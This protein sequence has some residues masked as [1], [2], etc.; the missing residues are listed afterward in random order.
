[1]KKFIYTFVPV[2][3]LSYFL[4]HLFVQSDSSVVHHVFFQKEIVKSEEIEYKTTN[5]FSNQNQNDFVN[6]T[7]WI[8]QKSDVIRKQFGKPTDIQPSLA[9]YESWIY[10][11]GNDKYI[12]FGMKNNV[13]KTIY[14]M[15]SGRKDTFLNIGVKRNELE[16]QYDFHDSVTL[17][18]PKSLYSI[19]LRDEEF[20]QKPFI[21]INNVFVQLYF[22]SNTQA[23]SSVRFLSKETMIDHQPYH[24]T[25]NGK[26]VSFYKPSKK[27]WQKLSE[28]NEKKIFYLTNVIRTRFNL[29]HLTWSEELSDVAYA[30]SKDMNDANYFDHTSPKEGSLKERLL[31][32]DLTF[33]YAG[34]NIA[35]NYKDGAGAVE[36]WLNSKSHRHALLNEKYTH[37]GVG[38]YEEYFTQ[39]FSSSLKK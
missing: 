5:P 30:H 11:Y 34:E 8:G 16:K 10:P 1:M 38:V 3:L 2:F 19:T 9:H 31:Q 20:K 12:E 21:I 37:L 23:L 29:P 17:K 35:K 13:V 22:D 33:Q 25:R 4:F 14:V 18:T 6:W 28:A 32:T 15:A 7:K 24:M 26:E 39:N 36:G 27:E